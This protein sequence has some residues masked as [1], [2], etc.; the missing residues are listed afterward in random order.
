MFMCRKNYTHGLRI[1]NATKPGFG[2]KIFCYSIFRSA[3]AAFG[4]VSAVRG[5]T[6]DRT[7]NPELNQ[8]HVCPSSIK[9]LSC[10]CYDARVLE[11]NRVKT[12]THPYI[13]HIFTAVTTLHAP[14]SHLP[15]LHCKNICKST[16]ILWRVF[17][18]FN[19]TGS[20]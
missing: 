10:W 17:H 12:P 4:L 15:Y 6:Y 11:L 7:V 3:F 8:C 19:G 13:I 5:I 20:V 18:F 2:C 14:Y 9:L 16:D 1:R